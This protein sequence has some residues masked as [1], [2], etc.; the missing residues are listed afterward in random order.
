MTTTS[1]HARNLQLSLGRTVVQIGMAFLAGSALYV[2]RMTTGTLLV[3]MLLHALWDFG[4][5]GSLATKATLRPGALVLVPVTFV[6][7]LV[8]AWYVVAGT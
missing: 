3:C 4:T 1:L 7:G 6:L 8:A 2:T 5:L